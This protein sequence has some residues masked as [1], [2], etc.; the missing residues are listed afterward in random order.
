MWTGLNSICIGSSGVGCVHS[1]ESSH[2]TT[3]ALN[4]KLFVLLSLR[5]K[6][7]T[8]DCAKIHYCLL[9]IWSEN[10]LEKKN[11]LGT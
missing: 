3:T 11:Y 7:S 8:F 4:R 6:Q 10:Q 2:S 1:S 5:A 9:N